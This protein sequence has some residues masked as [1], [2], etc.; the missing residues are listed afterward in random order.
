MQSKRSECWTILLCHS[1]PIWHKVASNTRRWNQS[2]STQK[3]LPAKTELAS[4][5]HG[6]C[7]SQDT[8]CSIEIQTVVYKLSKIRAFCWSWGLISHIRICSCI[9][10]LLRNLYSDICYCFRH[11]QAFVHWAVQTCVYL[12]LNLKEKADA[13]VAGHL[14]EIKWIDLSILLTEDR[15]CIK[16]E[17]I[18]YTY[19]LPD[20]TVCQLEMELC[21]NL[22][23]GLISYLIA[24]VYGCTSLTWQCFIG[25]VLFRNFLRGS[26]GTTGCMCWWWSSRSASRPEE[27]TLPIIRISFSFVCVV[28]WKHKR[29]LQQTYI[30]RWYTLNYL[31]AYRLQWHKDCIATLRLLES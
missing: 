2:D 18:R 10:M 26:A 20:C 3:E 14:W 22:S 15:Y 12:I 7:R 25:F 4:W 17:C 31:V 6:L 21:E 16:L 28:S 13:T 19:V 23:P 9:I 27:R 29:Y 24:A 11:I 5:N 8:L 1:W 30:S